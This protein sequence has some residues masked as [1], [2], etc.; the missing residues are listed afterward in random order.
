MNRFV[1][2]NAQ[3]CV[4]CHACEVACVMAHNG[5]KHVLQAE[6]FLPR[7]R[8]IKA[9]GRA[10][11]Q[12]TQPWHTTARQYSQRQ[13]TTA[14]VSLAAKMR[15]TPPRQDPDKIDLTLRKT[16][17]KEIYRTF[18]K[19]QAESQ[20]DRCL[21]CG[22]HSVCEWTCPLHNHIPQWIELVKEG[23]VMEAVELSHQTNCLP[24]VTGRVC[25]QDRLCEKPA[26]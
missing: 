8:V 15:A 12:E 18:S 22:E 23:R 21:K 26:R 4:G 19:S 10:A 14:D 24:E 11:A 16:G 17:F 20:A 3:Q 9:A 25:P 2:A 1:L 6:Q 13:P 7:I 5:E